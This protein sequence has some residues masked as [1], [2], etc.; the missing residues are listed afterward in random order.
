[1]YRKRTVKLVVWIL[2]E[3]YGLARAEEW[4]WR[5]SQDVWAS[6]T[7]TMR[8]SVSTLTF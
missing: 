8:L 3:W 6:P 5:Q 1:M 7:A 2:R 4:G